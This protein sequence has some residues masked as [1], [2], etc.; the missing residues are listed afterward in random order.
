MKANEITIDVSTRI[1]VDEPTAKACLSLLTLYCQD[2]DLTV[3]MDK[4]KNLVFAQN[5]T[6]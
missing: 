4:Y 1:K 3:E 2:N 6:V 5:C